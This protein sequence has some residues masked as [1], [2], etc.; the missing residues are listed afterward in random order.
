M[1]KVSVIIPAYNSM[2]FLPET[3]DSVL[4]QTFADF[5][6]LI[7]NDGSTDQLVEWASGLSDHRVRLI[8]QANQGCAIARNTGILS[9]R[10]AY[11][12]FL[13]ADDIWEP[14]K[15]EKQVAIL[16][17]SPNIGL[18]NTWISNIDAQGDRVGKLSGSD[19][20]GYVWESVIEDNP[21]M[22][23]SIPM[24]RRQCFE[25]VGLFDQSLR[26]AEDW[27]MWIR[28]AEK[29]EFAVV[30][31]PLVRYRVHAHS[32]SHNL[33]L[34]LQSRL[35]VIEKAFQKKVPNRAIQKDKV[36]GHV[37]LSV[38]YRALQKHDFE[39]ALDLKKQA[40]K[41]YPNLFYSK[42]FH[43]LGVI[44]LLRRRLGDRR[45]EQLLKALRYAA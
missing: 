14:T 32:K 30:K 10:G 41:Y 1:P 16:E 31:G 5:E 9:S 45:Y 2:A 15:L 27:D 17:S 29:Y 42:V 23:G 35:K 26:S 44:L 3:L 24:I 39:T 13:D 22:C 25:R 33:Q 4:T 8:N 6:V 21:I 7:V 11:I 38:A 20:E 28:I 43:R 40:L 36:Y 19:A 37:F 18:V 12:A 34:H